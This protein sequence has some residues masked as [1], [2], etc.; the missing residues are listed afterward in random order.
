[1]IDIIGN[2]IPVE[3]ETFDEEISAWNSLKAEAVA[4]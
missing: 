2:L 4:P 3:A 1:M